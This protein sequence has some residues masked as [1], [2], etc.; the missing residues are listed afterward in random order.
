MFRV[1]YEKRGLKVPTDRNA[2]KM[3]KKFL[4]DTK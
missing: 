1:T 2:K 4:T 3:I